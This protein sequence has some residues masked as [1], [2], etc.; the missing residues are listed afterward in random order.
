[1]TDTSTCIRHS[2]YGI[3]KGIMGGSAFVHADSLSCLP[4]TQQKWLL[5][6]I[7]NYSP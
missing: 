6:F 7:H 3:G 4:M 2:I 1:M 5:A